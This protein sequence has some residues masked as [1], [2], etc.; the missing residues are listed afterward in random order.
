MTDIQYE[1]LPSDMVRQLCDY[2]ICNSHNLIIKPENA[3]LMKAISEID[4]RAFAQL[5]LR[6]GWQGKDLWK[7]QKDNKRSAL[8]LL[9]TYE[10]LSKTNNYVSLDTHG[11]ISWDVSIDPEVWDFIF[12]NAKLKSN[13]SSIYASQSAPAYIRW[14]ES[15]P[16]R[17]LK[18]FASADHYLATLM[19]RSYTSGE[20]A[21]KRFDILAK[22]L[23]FMHMWNRDRPYHMSALFQNAS[24]ATDRDAAF[25]ELDKLMYSMCCIARK[26]EKNMEFMKNDMES[27]DFARKAKGRNAWM[28]DYMAGLVVRN[29]ELA[30]K[31]VKEIP[32][33]FNTLPAEL[34]RKREYRS[35]RRLFQV[36]GFI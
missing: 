24:R 33:L 12:G 34:R 26:D 23:G 9:N 14:Y 11:D 21:T 25:V 18:T 31:I 16:V 3:E 7:L 22:T 19:P 5:R 6:S 27:Q 1:K 17:S 35:L 30:F 8:I 29:E 4:L 20:D 10:E 13:L 36:G 15:D 2:A 32:Y 28:P